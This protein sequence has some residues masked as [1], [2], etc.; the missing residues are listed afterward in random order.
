MEQNIYSKH[1]KIKSIIIL[2][3]F[4]SG[5]FAV[6]NGMH[7]SS[8]LSAI[9]SPSNSYNDYTDIPQ[10]KNIYLN[11]TMDLVSMLS[12]K[13]ITS[14][15]ASSRITSIDEVTI[16]IDENTTSFESS[17]SNDFIANIESIDNSYSTD[18]SS[19]TSSSESILEEV[20]LKSSNTSNSAVNY[21]DYNDYRVYDGSDNYIYYILNTS[22]YEK[23]YNIAMYD[24]IKELY[25][26]DDDYVLTYDIVYS[27]CGYA[28]DNGLKYANFKKQADN[29]TY[30]TGFDTDVWKYDYLFSWIM[31]NLYE[32]N[33]NYI[34]C[35]F[36]VNEWNPS[37]LKFESMR[38]SFQYLSYK[39]NESIAPFYVS[40]SIFFLLLL[41][42]IPL[43]GHKKGIKEIALSR[44][45][46]LYM[47]IIG[48]IFFLVAML[49][50]VFLADILDNVSR[51]S[52]YTY[53]TSMEMPIMLF[54]IPVMIITLLTFTTVIKRIKTH[55]FIKS[56]YIAKI[57]LFIYKV[58]K[59]IVKYV[60]LSI[61]NTLKKIIS[62]WK[63][64]FLFRS[65]TMQMLIM[66]IVFLLYESVFILFTIGSGY[67]GPGLLFMFIG[68]LAFSYFLIRLGGDIN[69]MLDAAEKISNGSINTT[70]D[71]DAVITPMKNLAHQMNSISTGLTAAVEARIKSERLK[72]ELITNVSHDIKTPLTSIITYV[73][74]LDKEDLN[75]EKAHEYIAVLKEKSWRLKTLI[76][77]LV[78]ASK[79]STGNIILT[80]EKLNLSELL[81]QSAGEFEDRFSER[82]L[83]LILNLPDE[84]VI[85]SA[86][87]K[88]TYRII[89]NL[90]SNA[91]KY[92]L[93]HTRIYVDVMIDSKFAYTVIKNISSERLNISTD[94]L[95]ERFVRGDSS[96]NTEGSGLGLSIANSLSDLQGG[97]FDIHVDGDLFKVTVK[98]PLFLDLRLP[99]FTLEINK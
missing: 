65:T 8:Y 90:F 7:V 26:L 69:Q 82:E 93:A 68:F 73:D 43:I 79:A 81:K 27:L 75:N 76:E 16:S 87:G 1:I 19:V 52:N 95:L 14:S 9:G 92:A 35:T 30:N 22:T 59:K 29:I 4:I 5:G 89:D 84:P 11:Y 94:E 98:L 24:Y 88:S 51:M 33:D 62:T 64:F 77:D 2:L 20:K 86:D 78:E 38:Y 96:R 40:A 67:Y 85:I 41:F 71:P 12:N 99:D 80:I 61:K 36:Y 57:T 53:I 50:I 10:F 70:I 58:F 83:E 31:E 39:Y 72:T 91:T 23:Y 44:F 48:A 42:L 56:F 49:Y 18:S 55:T 45:D 63:S 6:F 3:L 28:V 60:L 37:S 21:F 66:L 32:L 17:T 74:L 97:S 25:N 47:E 13:E 54:Y 46:R 34:I 15:N